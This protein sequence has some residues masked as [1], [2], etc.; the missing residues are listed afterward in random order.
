MM[1]SLDGRQINLLK[2]YALQIDFLLARLPGRKKTLADERERAAFA[3]LAVE[4]GRPDLDGR[5]LLFHPETL[6]RWHRELIA[7][8]FDGSAQRG[9]G[10]PSPWHVLS[11]AA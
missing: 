1:S 2:F 3:R 4:I 5:T 7:K 6:F 9:P 8:K 10:R 11:T